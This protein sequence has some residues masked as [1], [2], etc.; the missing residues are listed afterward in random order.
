MPWLRILFSSRHNPRLHHPLTQ[1]N[2]TSI[3]RGDQ[4]TSKAIAPSPT[5]WCLLV[6]GEST[7]T[8]SSPSPS[9]TS[10]PLLCAPPPSLLALK[11]PNTPCLFQIPHPRRHDASATSSS[12]MKTSAGLSNP[13]LSETNWALF[14]DD[15]WVQWG[16]CRIRGFEGLGRDKILLFLRVFFTLVE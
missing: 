4:S 5:A 13:T 9:S 6:Q 1:E 15:A 10:A 12:L 16:I 14:E 11:H 7:T 2:I 8:P 3:T